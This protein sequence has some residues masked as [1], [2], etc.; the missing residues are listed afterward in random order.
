LA[1]RCFIAG[2]QNRNGRLWRRKRENAKAPRN[3]KVV[4]AA[5]SLRRRW[6]ADRFRHWPP[7]Y[8]HAH[9]LGVAWRLGVST[10]VLV[11]VE[12]GQ[13]EVMMVANRPEPEE[14]A[15][16]VYGMKLSIAFHLADDASR[17]I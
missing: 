15:L 16:S 14:R 12:D 8:P 9:D 6:L 11:I 3:A 7:V 13:H 10:C 4:L 2:C 17:I 1:R 5:T